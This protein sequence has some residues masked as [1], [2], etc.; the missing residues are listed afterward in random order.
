MTAREAMEQLRPLSSGEFFAFGPALSL[1]VQ[2]LKVGPVETTH[3]RESGAAHVARAAEAHRGH[4]ARAAKARRD[5]AQGSGGGSAIASRSAQGTRI[6]VRRELAQ[7]RR[8]APAPRDN[9][10]AAELRAAAVTIKRLGR[11]RSR[12]S[13]NSS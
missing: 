10:S 12:P 3:P 5:L 9:A 11:A 8:A 6:V 2:K 1:T 13:R 4:Q 7:A